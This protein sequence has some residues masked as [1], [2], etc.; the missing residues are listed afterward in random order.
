MRFRGTKSIEGVR[1]TKRHLLFASAILVSIVIFWSPIKALT[2]L[3]IR[4]DLYSHIPFMPVLIGCFFYAKRKAI[5]PHVGYSVRTGIS[6][7]AIGAVLSL[8]CLALGIS[9]AR[10]DALCLLTISLLLVW[11]GVFVLFYGAGTLERASFPLLLAL[12]MI[13]LPNF[14]NEAMVGALRRSSADVVYPVLRVLGLPVLREGYVFHFP[15]MSIRI[16]EACSGLHS[17]IGLLITSI[18]AGNLLLTKRWTRTVAIVSMV[19]LAIVKNALR[20]VILSLIA[21]FMG[22]K[23]FVSNF[24][25]LVGFSIV[26]LFLLWAIIALLK[27]LETRPAYEEHIV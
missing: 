5:F 4:D 14:L 18:I 12:F 1:N 9:L 24:H 15:Q 26:A 10:N 13:P 20:I 6:V 8:A 27:K 7:V 23:I 19:P 3:S 2:A 25:R 16:A 22:E 21:V 17:F 11:T